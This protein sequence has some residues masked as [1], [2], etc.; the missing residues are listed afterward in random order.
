MK[1]THTTPQKQ[2]RLTEFGNRR[3]TFKCVD[4]DTLKRC[5][6]LMSGVCLH[7]RCPKCSGT[8]KRHNPPPKKLRKGGRWRWMN[9]QRVL[10]QG[11]FT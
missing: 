4:C 8:M 2:P 5:P 10:P 7:T 9:G 6:E 11:A 3:L 1:P